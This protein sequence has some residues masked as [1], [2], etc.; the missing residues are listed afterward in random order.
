MSIFN[1]KDYDNSNGIQSSIFGPPSWFVLHVT[2]FN[3]PVKP[4]K[5]DKAHYK[6][7]LLSY[8]YTLPCLYCRQNFVTNLKSA[9]FCDNVFKNRDTFSRFI[10]KLHN[11]VNKMLGKTIKISY[12]EVRDR[13]ENFRS[14]CGKDDINKKAKEK[15]CST[16]LHG[17]KSKC[18]I[19][20]VPKSSKKNNFKVDP[21]CL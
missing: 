2:S 21:K 15:S 7:W 17:K 6:T 18:I 4:T 13:Y 20:I 11:C 5:D 10:Y 16:S 8:R 9:G 12:I 1:K 14:R 3:Y 19:N